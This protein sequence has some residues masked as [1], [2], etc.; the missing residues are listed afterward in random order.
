MK[1]DINKQDKVLKEFEKVIVELNGLLEI[2][3]KSPNKNAEVLQG[4]KATIEVMEKV[5]DTMD[6]L[7]TELA[8]WRMMNINFVEGYKLLIEQ[9]GDFPAMLMG[10]QVQVMRNHMTLQIEVYNTLITLIRESNGN[11]KEI[12]RKANG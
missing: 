7:T 6:E 3:R 1:N 4:K 8:K 5:R 12:E 10:E 2:Y 9:D 11:K